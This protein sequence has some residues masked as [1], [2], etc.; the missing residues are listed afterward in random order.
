M[1]I[2]KAPTVEKITLVKPPNEANSSTK[3]NAL[4]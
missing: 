2:P 4:R 3:V 1:K